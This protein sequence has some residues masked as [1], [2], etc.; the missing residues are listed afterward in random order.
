M[1]SK[2]TESPAAEPHVT[3]GAE[4]QVSPAAKPRRKTVARRRKVTHELIEQRAYE[5]SLGESA[6]SPFDNWLIAERELQA[7]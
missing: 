2:K 7:K 1:P 6:G 5:L 3:P 4:P